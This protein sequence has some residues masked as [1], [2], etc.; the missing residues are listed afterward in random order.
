M[1]RKAETDRDKAEA[2]IVAAEARAEVARA[3]ARRLQ[4]LL[5]YT[6]IRAPYDGIVTSRRVNT[7]DLVQ[8]NNGKGEGLF[9]V[10]RLNP[11]RL[12]VNVPEAEAGLVKE[13]VAVRL[14]L[15]ALKAP[16]LT[17]KVTRTSWALE[18]GSRTLR[19][20]IDMPNPDGRLRPGTYLY[21]H[22]TGQLPQ[23]WVV[24]ATAVVKQGDAVVCFLIEGD[25]AV[26][27]PV[28]VGHT[29]GQLT[30]VLRVQKAGTLPAWVE[31]TGK[32]AVASKAAGLVD[33]QSVQV[34]SPAKK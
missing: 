17:G 23:A 27:A 30:E 5:D 8:P 19:T 29:D 31:F 14:N 9:T 24:P 28:Q 22:L 2:D 11:V 7:G 33:G 6:K 21:A 32:E 1:V 16:M 12:V 34:E 3:D 4:A 18:P 13:N 15:P 25:K 10:A 26:R 20:E